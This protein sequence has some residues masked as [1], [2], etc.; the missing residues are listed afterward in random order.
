MSLRLPACAVIVISFPVLLLGQEDNNIPKDK[1]TVIAP[2]TE[3]LGDWMSVKIRRF[4]R[5]PIITSELFADKKDGK[6]ING[7]T[8][9][10]APD[11][12]P[13][14]LGKYYLYFGHHSGSYIRLAYADALEGPWKLHQGGVLP[15]D[16]LPVK[17]DHISSPDVIVDEAAKRIIL[18]YHG[19][20]R[21]EF[22]PANP[23]KWNGQLTFAATSEDGITFKPGSEVIS[24]FYL[25]V[26][27]HEGRYYGI[28]K[29]GNV[30][31]Q[32]CRGDG[33]PLTG[34]ERGSAFLPN[35]RHFAVLPRGDNLWVFFS[36]A[37]D[38]PEQI[39]LT[40]VNLKEDWSKWGASAPPPVS[41]LKP[42]EAW[43]GIQ[44]ELKPSKWGSSVKVQELRDPC[45]FEE[46]GK[47][48]L[49]YSVAGEMGIA[50]AE[51]ELDLSA[52]E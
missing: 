31:G 41:V 29:D 7:P 43:E 50:I 24:E 12:L 25:R 2:T 40:R 52:V 6:N 21:Q 4:S 9:I 34:F 5:N 27:A 19:T 30:G 13:N 51:M 16:Q 42:E 11:W 45:V 33:N 1:K 37:G 47:L 20:V 10:K 23:G 8:L 39:L 3:P 36:R 44:Y 32:F 26:F 28:C 17:M 22:P 46:D 49:L 48:Y 35:S 14:P 18:Y 15:L 38:C